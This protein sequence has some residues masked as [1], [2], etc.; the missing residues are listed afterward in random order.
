MPK[1]SNKTLV[2]NLWLNLDFWNR[3]LV[4]D[5]QSGC[6]NWNA[7]MHRQ[8]YGFCGGIRDTDKK[9]I[10]TVTHRI[11]MMLHLGRNLGPDECVIHTCGNNRCCNPGHLFVGTRSD[12]SRLMHLNGNGRAPGPYLR[13]YKKAYKWTEE[14]IQ[15]MRV[16]TV[17]E[18]MQRF[19]VHERTR[20]SGMRWNARKQYKWLQYD[21]QN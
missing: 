3:H 6:I 16:A 4:E 10:M 1:L 14:E 8:G 13:K 7:G 15:F 11:A 21:K 20:A 2:G 9:K 12:R 19:N 18:I 17:D 5:V